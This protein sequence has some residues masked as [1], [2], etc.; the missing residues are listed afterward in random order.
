MDGLG[1]FIGALVVVYLVPGPDMILILQSSAT[2]ER[3]EA[4]ATAA[5]LALARAAH[6]TVA[7]LGL[8]ALLTTSPMTF[9]VVRFAGAAFLIWLGIQILHARTLVPDAE[10]TQKPQRARSHVAAFHRGLLTNILNPKAL[11]FCSVLLPQF[12]QPGQASV[13]AHFG[14]LGLILVSVGL[15]FDLVYASAGFVLGRWIAGHP[16]AETLQRWA[17][18]T[19]LIGFGLRLVLSPQPV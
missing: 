13:V 16:L 12:I 8:A 3:G 17:F 18:A 7:A 2:G 4:L 6:V 11:L 14:L 1:M 15:A 5:G 9:Q 10:A 19:M